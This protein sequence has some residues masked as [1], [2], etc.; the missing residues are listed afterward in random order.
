MMSTFPNDRRYTSDHEWAK[1]ED[2]GITI[3]VSTFAVEQLGDITLV[4]IDA[5]P[6]D[7]LVAGNAFGSIESVKTLSD[8]LAPI[9]GTLVAIN[10]DL[11]DAPELVNEDCYNKGWMI[12]I[13]PADDAFGKL[14]DSA[15]Y[16][17]HVK[18][19]AH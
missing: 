18:Q 12:K 6:G 1:T 10:S 4:S 17:L 13:K 5:S 16:E 11:E 19:A 14:M 8:L 9:S 7:Q 3:G 15:A 2:D